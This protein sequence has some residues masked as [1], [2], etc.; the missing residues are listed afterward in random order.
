MQLRYPTPNTSYSVTFRRY[1]V[2]NSE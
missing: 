2:D 1:L